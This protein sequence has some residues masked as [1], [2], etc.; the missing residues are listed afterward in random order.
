M[1]TRLSEDFMTS[2]HSAKYHELSLLLREA[3]LLSSCGSVLSWDE[4]TYMPKGG[5]EHRAAQCS[6]IAGLAHERRTDPR[7]GELLGELQ[8]S[9][10]DLADNEEFVANIR[11]VRRSYDRYT[12]LPKR[13][14]E[15]ISRVTT[16]SQQ[17]WV[18]ARAKSRFDLFR[19][20]LEQVLALKREEA[21]A[22]SNGQG[23]PYDA[24]LDDYE[25][26][27]TAAELE[28]IF[29]PLASQ[30]SELVAAIS[31][32]EQVISAEIL[33][34]AFARSAQK[35]VVEQAAKKIGFD[36]HR[37]RIDES[38]HPFC[39]SFG[40]GDC[41]L[42]TR[43]QEEAFNSAFF[44]VLHEAG[45]G[46]YE[47]GLP[48]DK[49]GLPSGQAASLGVHES[50]SRLWE[51]L[52]GRSMAFWKGFFPTAQVNFPE[53]L[54][55]VTCEQFYAAINQVQPSFIRVEADEVTYNL[56]I[57]IRF[58]LERELLSGNLPVMDLPEAW[59]DRY[60]T[61]LH[62]RPASDRE[63]CLQ[64]IHWSAG[65]LGYFPTYALGNLY[66]AELMAA[67]S[68]HFGSLD[69]L[70][71]QQDFAALL[72]WLRTHIHQYGRRYAPRKLIEQAI[73]HPV[74]SQPLLDH[75]WTKFGT[76]YQIPRPV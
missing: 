19:P 31:V 16:L 5:A 54:A 48:A 12:K 3:E 41:R 58:E 60:D 13:L 67:A 56:H 64:D 7:I 23:D 14:V 4:Q 2:T 26:A 50:Q 40:P 21:A 43:Y 38:A 32:S 45:H 15:E 33:E 34:R 11:E 73:G 20:W 71:E 6:L 1:A 72:D 63:G 74:S 42:T 29:Q 62:I 53:V 66:A 76:L 35:T 55:D 22:V 68:A 52:V 65:L 75:L 70:I 18:D 44:G 57:M 17:A 46:M 39:S 28:Q 24:L 30:L 9:A 49:F 36:F 27:T 8:S 10:G 61:Y 69:Q 37:G 25:P 51:N 47:Q 59:N